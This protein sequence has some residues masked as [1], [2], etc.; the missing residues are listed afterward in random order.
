[1]RMANLRLKS[2]YAKYR[3]VDVKHNCADM[4][5]AEIKRINKLD[6]PQSELK[7][8]LQLCLRNFAIGF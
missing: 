7:A 8:G 3:Q 5:K 4:T 1:M 6:N 2:L